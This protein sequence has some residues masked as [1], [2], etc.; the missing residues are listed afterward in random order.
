MNQNLTDRVGSLPILHRN[1]QR[2]KVKQTQ[3][4]FLEVYR[5]LKAPLFSKRRQPR[6]PTQSYKNDSK[7]QPCE[8]S[9][10]GDRGLSGRRK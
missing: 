8:D 2:E 6:G 10:L 5:G 7:T 4:N 1:V 9:Q 3:G